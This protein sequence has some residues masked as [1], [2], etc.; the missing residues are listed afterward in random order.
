LPQGGA[1]IAVV[2]HGGT[3]VV[4]LSEAELAAIFAGNRKAWS[5]GAAIRLFNL[6]LGHP[7]RVEFDRVVLSMTPEQV[8][9]YWLDRRIRGEGTPPRQI[10][11]PELLAR[12]V[13]AL[14]GAISYLPE[15][16]VIPGLRV[17][18]RVRQGKVVG[19]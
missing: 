3:K 14:A 4:R 13:L 10:P 5:D 16:K 18:A 7:V 17:V 8:S 12:L 19:P 6:P 15:D 1:A 11:S 2:V 9:R